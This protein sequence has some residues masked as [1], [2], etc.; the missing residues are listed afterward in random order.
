MCQPQFY[1]PQCI[2]NLL[3]VSHACTSLGIKLNTFIDTNEHTYTRQ[4]CSK[5]L[6]WKSPK[7][8]NMCCDF[9]HFS[10]H[11]HRH[12]RH[13]S[14]ET[15]NAVIKMLGLCDICWALNERIQTSARVSNKYW[16]RWLWYPLKAASICIKEKKKK[17]NRFDFCCRR[18]I[19]LNRCIHVP[20]SFVRSFIHMQCIHGHAHAQAQTHT[21]AG[22]EREWETYAKQ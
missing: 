15:P 9:V 3:A 7:T 11:R 2:E 13:I 18:A 4:T 21:L 8:H 6:W 14:R 5:P 20:Y 1:W 12:R 17:L 19:Q 16:L 22:R 10:P